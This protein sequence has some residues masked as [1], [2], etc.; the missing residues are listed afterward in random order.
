MKQKI[1]NA[2]IRSYVMTKVKLEKFLD[3]ERGDTNFIS[4]IIILGIV[5]LLVIVFRGYITQILGAVGGQIS[6]FF[7]NTGGF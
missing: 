2:M 3:D 6:Q 5:I 4:I 7:S 1:Q